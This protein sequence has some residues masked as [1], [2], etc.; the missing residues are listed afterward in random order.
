MGTRHPDNIPLTAAYPGKA[1]I[2]AMAQAGWSVICA[3]RNCGLQLH[4]NL[5]MF[6]RVHGP[7][8]SLWNRTM[9]CP[10][11]G[12]LA[13]VMDFHAKPPMCT[14]YRRLVVDVKGPEP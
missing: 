1:S 9:R 3:C 4:C 14:S 7:A 12:C 6:E 5:P 13:G 8:Y 2:R 10:K 11:V